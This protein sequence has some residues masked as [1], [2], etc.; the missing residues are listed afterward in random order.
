M[1]GAM[2]TRVPAGSEGVAGV[3]WGF[4]MMQSMPECKV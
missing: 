1:T 3:L 2:L 4:I